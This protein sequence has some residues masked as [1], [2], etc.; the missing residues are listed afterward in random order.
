MAARHI[1]IGVKVD[2]DKQLDL[3][4]V[5]R[6]LRI[7]ADKAEYNIRWA[8]ESNWHITLK[9][10]GEVDDSKL[11]EIKSAL[12]ETARV[13]SASEIRASGLGGFPDERH[14]RVIYAGVAKSQALLDLQTAVESALHPLGFVGEERDYTPHI[15]LGRLRSAGSVSDLISPFVRKNFSR[16]HLGEL[17]LFETIQ[18]GSFSVYVSLHSSALNPSDTR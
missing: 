3:R 11:T 2:A 15:T 18:K 17:V 9:F 7:S 16:I 4:E 10:L 5:C 6:K 8:P 14:A 1:F 13:F 12:D